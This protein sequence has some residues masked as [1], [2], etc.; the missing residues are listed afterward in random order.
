MEF[1]LGACTMLV[2]LCCRS[3]VLR[4][5]DAAVR[6][7]SE[8]AALGDRSTCTDRQLKGSAI[9]S[10]LYPLQSWSKHTWVRTK[11]VRSTSMAMPLDL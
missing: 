2:E 4:E 6:D 11:N 9:G 1:N 7:R 5:L 8:L 3:D 10:D